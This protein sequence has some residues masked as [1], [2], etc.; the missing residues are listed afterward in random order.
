MSASGSDAMGTAAESKY[1]L[2]ATYLLG[3]SQSSE[4]CITNLFTD[5]NAE[6]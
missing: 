1:L 2:R 6:G 3:D 5:E 4:V